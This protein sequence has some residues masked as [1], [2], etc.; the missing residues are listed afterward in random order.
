MPKGDVSMS[1][2]YEKAS[3]ILLDRKPF[4]VLTGAGISVESGL[5]P[6]R[7]PGGIWTRYDP[8]DYGHVDTFNRNPERAWILLKDLIEGSLRARPN[9]AHYALARLEESGI[10]G[11][12][13]TQNVDGLHRLAGSKDVLDVHGDARMIYCPSCGIRYDIP[14]E[15][16]TSP[17][18]LCKCGSFLRPDIVFY[19]EQLPEDKIERAWMLARSGIDILVIGTSGVVFPVAHIPNLVKVSG[20]RIVLMDPNPSGLPMGIADVHI[21]EK[22]VKGMLELEKAL[23]KRK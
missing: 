22:A 8:E 7:G 14:E 4:L 21:K 9:E 10:S 15:E 2:P 12:I 19:G 6:F 20:G 23:M 16:M 5:P 13:I 1:N 11:T 18:P 17:S 3:A